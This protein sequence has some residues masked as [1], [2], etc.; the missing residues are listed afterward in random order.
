METTQ[1]ALLT[2]TLVLVTLASVLASLEN[3]RRHIM[4][5]AQ[6]IQDLKAKVDESVEASDRLEAKLAQ[7]RKDLADFVAN[8][9]TGLSQENKD[10]LIAIGEKLQAETADAN[11]QA[12]DQPGD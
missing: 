4:S 10:A 5:V 1:L 12:A 9:P 6:E 7:V 11:E 2:A 3:I 8:P